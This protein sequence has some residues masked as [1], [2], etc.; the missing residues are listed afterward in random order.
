MFF[1]LEDDDCIHVYASPADAVRSIE[2]LDAEECIRAAYD[3]EGR[4]HRIEWLQPNRYSRTFLGFQSAANGRYDLIPAG[5]AE[6][7]A[8]LALLEK[9]TPI[10]AGKALAS[11]EALRDRLRQ[12]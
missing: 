6:P 5:P 11:V 7:A 9:D 10:L 1:V 12:E 2:A 8:L 4:P 3:E